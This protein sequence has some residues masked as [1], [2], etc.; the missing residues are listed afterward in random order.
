[1]RYF[2]DNTWIDSRGANSVEVDHVPEIDNLPKVDG[3][4]GRLCST[5]I[6]C[7]SATS[8]YHCET[9][10]YHYIEPLQGLV[11]QD[12]YSCCICREEELSCL[13]ISILDKQNIEETQQ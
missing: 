7:S 3:I 10:L 13:S 12:D 4:E 2:L 9:S 6:N 5:L 1:V 11:S 8:V